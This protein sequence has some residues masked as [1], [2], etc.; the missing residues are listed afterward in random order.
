[1]TYSSKSEA[2][3]LVFN[4]L[5]I[6]QFATGLDDETLK[7]ASTVMSIVLVPVFIEEPPS[8]SVSLEYNLGKY[9][10]AHFTNV[11]ST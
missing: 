3:A 7:E 5:V 9:T 2:F 6:T 8:S 11:S 4:A 10:W 1:V